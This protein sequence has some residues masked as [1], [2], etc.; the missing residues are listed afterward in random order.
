MLV[1]HL[2]RQA[3]AQPAQRIDDRARHVSALEFLR[4]THINHQR[5]D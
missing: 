5:V 3:L 1:L 2:T 4:Q